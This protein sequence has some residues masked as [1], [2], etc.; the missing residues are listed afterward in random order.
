MIDAMKT[1]PASSRS[2]GR[3]ND[4]T[5]KTMAGSGEQR[6]ALPRARGIDRVVHI[7]EYLYRQS[8]PLRPNEIATGIGAPKSTVYEIVNRLLD[9][10]I[11]ETFETEGRVFLGRRLHYY[12]AAYLGVFDLAREAGRFLAALREETRETSQLCLLEGDKY[13][14]ALMEEGARHFKISSDLGRKIPITW[15]ASGRVFVAGMSDTEILRFVPEEDFV[16]P[17]GK[18]LPTETFLRQVRQARATGF[19]SCDSI[20]DSFAHCFAVPVYSETRQCVAT[21]CLVV[22]REDATKRHQKLLATL[23]LHASKLSERLGAD[24]AAATSGV[25]DAIP[26]PGRKTGS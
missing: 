2:T 13:T 22:P 5:K 23:K 14:V 19:Y 16:L 9:A 15:T 3:A 8:K 20:L 26:R 1:P 21:M 12:G 18:R 10:R 7:L 24:M 4:A 17:D 25:I 6:A 11:L